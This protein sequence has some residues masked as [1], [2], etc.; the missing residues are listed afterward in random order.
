MICVINF[1]IKKKKKIV[2]K[3]FCHS[4]YQHREDRKRKQDDYYDRDRRSHKDAKYSDYGVSQTSP[5][6]NLPSG[7]MATDS[8]SSLWPPSSAG[9]DTSFDIV[10]E[11]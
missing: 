2:L 7:A 9:D 11:L 1:V 10:Q 6:G 8:Q 5:P 4:R 3:R